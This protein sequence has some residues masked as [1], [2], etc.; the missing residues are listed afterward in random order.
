[1][2]TGIRSMMVR[3]MAGVAA[4]GLLVATGCDSD[5]DGGNADVNGS[6]SLTQAFSSGKS[7]TFTLTFAQNGTT[8][9]GTSAYGPVNGSVSGD[10][11]L[12][13]IQDEDLK[14]FEG[15]VSGTTMGGTFTENFEDE[16]FRNGAWTATRTSP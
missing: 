8:L 7:V 11:I 5:G 2:S 16:L 13:T 1:M 4:I 12:F 15:T 6:W 10:S 9:T 3:L 14:T